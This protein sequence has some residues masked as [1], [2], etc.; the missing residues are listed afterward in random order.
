LRDGRDEKD[1]LDLSLPTVWL[2]GNLFWTNYI[3]DYISAGYIPDWYWLAESE[4]IVRPVTKKE[5]AEAQKP[6]GG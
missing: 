2:F 5:R 6:C 1:G 4:S 3:R